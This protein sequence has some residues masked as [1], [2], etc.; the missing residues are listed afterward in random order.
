VVNCPLKY[1]IQ[2]ALGAS[3]CSHTHGTMNQE[4]VAVITTIR[5]RDDRGQDLVLPAPFDE[6]C[7]I[8]YGVGEVGND[9]RASHVPAE[10]APSPVSTLRS[11]RLDIGAI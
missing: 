1:R 11:P 3:G 6:S 10:P 5:S 4:D 7:W 9:R 8:K 2:V